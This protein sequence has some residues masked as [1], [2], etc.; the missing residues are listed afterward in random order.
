MLELTDGQCAVS[1]LVE[2]G[3]VLSIGYQGGVTL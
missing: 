3:Q 1:V 2:G